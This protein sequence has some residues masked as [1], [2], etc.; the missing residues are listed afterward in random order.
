M[1]AYC[2][3][4]KDKYKALSK[5]QSDWA[6]TCLDKGQFTTPYG[7]T[8][9]FPDTK[10]MAKTGYITNTTSIYNFPVNW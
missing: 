9:F 6:Y 5:M 2:E 3:Y 1:Q 4:F 8:F 7:M 10:M